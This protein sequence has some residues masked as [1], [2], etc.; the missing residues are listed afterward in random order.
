MSLR[1]RRNEKLSLNFFGPSRVLERIGPV[2]Y[3]LELP[4]TASIHSVFHVSQLKGVLRQHTEVHQLVPFK[5]EN[6]E[7]IAEQ[8]EVYGY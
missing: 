1:R 2:A 8:R 4:Q 7:W 3:K 5:S 6:H